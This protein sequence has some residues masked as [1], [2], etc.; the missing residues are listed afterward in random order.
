MFC[1]SIITENACENVERLYWYIKQT[2]VSLFYLFLVFDV[3][4]DFCQR[5]SLPVL[6]KRLKN[7]VVN[8]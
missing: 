4:R 7:T 2:T 6:K 3:P 1:A 5:K 8:N